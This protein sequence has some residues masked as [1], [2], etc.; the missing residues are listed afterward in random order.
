MVKRVKVVVSLRTSMCANW[1]PKAA[2]FNRNL[3]PMDL[4]I[5][6]CTV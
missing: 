5:I 6:Q 1:A 3:R 4:Q 2:R